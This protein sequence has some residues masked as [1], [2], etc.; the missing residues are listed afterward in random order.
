MKHTHA[1][2]TLVETIIVIAVM[3]ILAGL[4][5]TPIAT[6]IN[7]KRIQDEKNTQIEIQRAMQ[8]YAAGTSV[9]PHHVATSN[10][11][12]NTWAEELALYSNLSVSQIDTDVWGNARHYIRK[13]TPETFLGSTVNIY[14]ATLISRG[15]DHEADPVAGEIPVAVGAVDYTAPV[16]PAAATNWWAIADFA[17]LEPA[18]DDILIKYNDYQDKVKKY[19]T[20]LERM[21]KI[22]EAL[23]AYV[24]TRFLEAEA[25][26]EAGRATKIFFPRSENRAADPADLAVYGDAVLIEMGIYFAATGD[27]NSLIS[28]NSGTAANDAERRIEMIQMMRLLGLPDSYCCNALEFLPGTTDEVP[29]FY[30]SNP[31]PRIAGGCA[32]RPDGVTAGRTIFLPPRLVTEHFVDTNIN[33]TCG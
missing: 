19:E 4:M 16:G 25:A 29:F 20:T 30:F 28:N 7:Q 33:R 23:D 17:A 10:P 27:N 22:S 9:L 26:N 2:F 13:T 11:G 6:F 14:Y 31:R 24:K 3:S 12:N 18:D 32:D 21:N 1:G 5:S 8:L 15:P